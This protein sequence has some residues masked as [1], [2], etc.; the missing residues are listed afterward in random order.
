M[1]TDVHTITVRNS[2]RCRSR[3]QDQVQEV[4]ITEN[5]VLKTRLLRRY[6]E[7]QEATKDKPPEER[8]IVDIPS[9]IIFELVKNYELMSRSNKN[10]RRVL[11]KRSKTIDGIRDDLKKKSDEL[12][13]VSSFAAGLTQYL[14]MCSF[15]LGAFLELLDAAT[16]YRQAVDCVDNASAAQKP[17]ERLS[18]EIDE[19]TDLINQIIEELRE[20][21]RV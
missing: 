13:S 4:P 15:V 20:S 19:S 12:E 2:R 6:L 14:T 21:E 8:T 5:G 10:M 11:D 9:S 18:T 1:K 7:E 16:D 3:G 17:F